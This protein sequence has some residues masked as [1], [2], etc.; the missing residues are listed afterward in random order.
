MM[1]SRKNAARLL[2]LL[3]GVLL[4]GSMNLFC[5][6]VDVDNDDD[7]PPVNVELSILP[8]ASESSHHTPANQA[9]VATIH[10]SAETSAQGSAPIRNSELQK[11]AIPFSVPLRC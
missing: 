1:V 5:V 4:N 7:T 2:V 8:A 11:A 10:A 6:A 9:S 3:L